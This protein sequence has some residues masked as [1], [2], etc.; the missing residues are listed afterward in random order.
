MNIQCEER[1]RVFEGGT[2]AEWAALEAHSANCAVC[3]EELRSWKAL[4]TTAQEL[5]DYSDAPSLW[6]SIERALTEE[7]AAKKNR[8]GRRGWFTW[9]RG[10]TLG[11]QTAAAAALVLVLTV[12]A[13]WVYLHRS[14]PVEP[15][16]HSLLK[17]SALAEVE[18]AQAAYEQAIDKLAAQTKPQLENPA[19]PLQASYREKLLVLDS[20]ISDL[21]AQAGMNPSNAQLRQQLLAMYQEKQ[22]TLEEVLEEKR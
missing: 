14:K 3:A 8:A 10:F 6:P 9:S 19:T 16:D 5:R 11:L 13:G 15:G 7:A 18:R 22:Q 4:G 12:S 17:S 21:R 1:D 20:A 2:P